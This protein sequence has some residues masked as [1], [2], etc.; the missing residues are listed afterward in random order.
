MRTEIVRDG[1]T[2]TWWHLAA[3]NGICG[4][5]FIDFSR[6]LPGSHLLLE[7]RFKLLVYGLFFIW[8]II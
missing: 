2:D 4:F 3:I 7:C 6:L 8:I 1:A 5:R